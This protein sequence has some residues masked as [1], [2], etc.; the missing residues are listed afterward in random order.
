MRNYE[1]FRNVL[2]LDVQRLTFNV[3]RLNVHLTPGYFY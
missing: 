3:E 2:T 1:V